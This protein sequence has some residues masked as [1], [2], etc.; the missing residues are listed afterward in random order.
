MLLTASSERFII[1]AICS[2]DIPDCFIMR[3]ASARPSMIPSAR[4]STIPS[5]R[6]STIPSA[7][8]SIRPS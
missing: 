2:D 3:I 1:F 8:P 7:L 5:A 4:P 6:P